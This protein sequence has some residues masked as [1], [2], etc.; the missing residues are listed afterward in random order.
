MNFQYIKNYNEKKIDELLWDFDAVSV[1]PSAMWGENSIYPRIETAYVFAE[2]IYMNDK[3]V[4][5]FNTQTFNQGSA[6][7]K[8]TYYN[9]K[10]LILQHLPVKQH[11]KKIVINRMR[12][13]YFIDHLT[14]VVFQE[15]VK[16]RGNVIEIYGG[17]IY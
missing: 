15:I 6:I 10:N 11:E 7:F 1:Y 5:K 16:I 13:G 14:S 17:V 8:N 12:N 2:D 9:P 3:L 4:K